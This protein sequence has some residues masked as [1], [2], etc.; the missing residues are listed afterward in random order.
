MILLMILVFGFCG[1][2][3]AQTSQNRMPAQV[4]TTQAVSIGNLV[5]YKDGILK[6]EM[7]TCGGQISPAVTFKAL[8]EVVDGTA[9]KII[10]EKAGEV[11]IVVS[12]FTTSIDFKTSAK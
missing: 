1:C 5:E 7:D 10:F 12:R 11:E 8:E 4:A 9:S 3:S 2:A 6:I